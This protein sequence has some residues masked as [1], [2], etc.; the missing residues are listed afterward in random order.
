M[1]KI[2]NY[3]GTIA[4]YYKGSWY[5][6]KKTIN[7]FGKTVYS[8]LGG[9]ATPEEAEESYYKYLKIF[10]D[11]QSKIISPKVN[12]DILLKDYL[13]YWYESI[14][15]ERVKSTTSMTVSYAIYKLIIPNL[16]YDI[17]LTHITTEYINELLESINKLGTSTANKAREILFLALKEAWLEKYITTNPVEKSK[18][19]RRNNK[20]IT[21]LKEDEIKKM[22]EVTSKENWY[23]EIL[24]ALFCGLRKGEIM[25][26][27]FTDFDF[28][29]NTVTISRQVAT[30][31]TMKANEFNISNAKRIETEPK[32]ENSYRTLKV[33]KMIM[34]EVTKRKEYMKQQKLILKD[35]FIDNDY[36]TCQKNGS[37][38]SAGSLNTYLQKL[39]KRLNFSNITIHGLRHMYA[40]ILIEQNVALPKISSLL[41]HNS[42][43]TTYNIYCGVMNDNDRILAFMNNKFNVKEEINE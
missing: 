12:K 23:L 35:N 20:P 11:E 18:E 40:T 30:N 4:F 41:G 21:I 22:L 15:K 6:R 26:L 3:K 5:H 29:R 37:A 17:K 16:M 13:I 42:I 1:E 2:K 32:T 27:K 14:L 19:Y 8:R 10:E 7:E 31:F 38:R 28:K 43:H 36:I 34:V 33:P 39:S 25:G 24:L 9:F